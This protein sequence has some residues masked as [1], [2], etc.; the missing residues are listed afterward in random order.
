MTLFFFDGRIY[1]ADTDNH[2]V[3]EFRMGRVASELTGFNNPVNI[4]V[5]Q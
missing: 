4:R 2:R 3:V 1:V 5:V